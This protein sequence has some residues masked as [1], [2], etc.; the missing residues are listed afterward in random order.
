MP[1]SIPLATLCR[2]LQELPTDVGSSVS[3]SQLD[4]AA[5]SKPAGTP[6]SEPPAEKPVGNRPAEIDAA[7]LTEISNNMVSVK[8]GTFTM[9]CQD[10][11]DK[12]CGNDEK[13]AH[14]VTLSDF[15]ISKYEVTQRQWEAV[16]VNNPSEFK[17]YP[18]CPVEQVSWEDVQDFLKRLNDLTG[19][20]YRLPTEAEWEYAARGGNQSQD[21]QYSGGN[22]LSTVAWYYNNISGIKIHPVGQKKGNALGLYDMSGNVYEWCSDWYEGYT[23]ESQTNPKG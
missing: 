2:D 3:I 18:D 17:G 14:Q 6:V 22:E 9:G 10:G 16:M 19:Q 23:A 13:P 15:Q 20:R 21:F 5:D 12:D 7:I 11:R 1:L 4:L 8:G